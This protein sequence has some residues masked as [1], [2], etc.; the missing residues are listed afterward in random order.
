MKKLMVHIETE[1]DYEAVDEL[2]SIVNGRYSDRIRFPKIFR[3]RVLVEKVNRLAQTDNN[4]YRKLCDAS[5]F[6]K[7]M[8]LSVCV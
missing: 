1:D 3:D 7:T 8:Q 4:L 6:V 5:L 2:R